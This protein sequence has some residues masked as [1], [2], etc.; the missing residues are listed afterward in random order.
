MKKHKKVKLIPLRYVISISITILEV[1]LVIGMVVFWCK[2]YPY[3]LSFILIC[4]I[5]CIISILG[6][7]NNPDYKIPWLLV[8]TLL[9][10]AGYMLYL[11]FASRK[12]SQKNLIKLKKLAQNGYEKDDFLNFEKLKNE[13]I[14]SY[15]QFKMLSKISSTNLFRKTSTNYY[16]DINDLLFDLLNDL[17]NAKN[18]M[19]KHD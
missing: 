15:N 9:P 5:L 10:V 1:L 18:F 7:D 2:K 12:V 3:F 17:K 14:A 6:S 4:E 16:G 11:I 19:A 8:I 13:D